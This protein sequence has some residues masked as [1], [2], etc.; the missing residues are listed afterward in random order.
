VNL[1]VTNPLTDP[2]WTELVLNHPRSSAFHQVGFLRA[3]AQTYE[4]EPAVVTASGPDCSLEDGL[5]FCRI[6][7]FLTGKRLV[8]LPFA[9]HCDPLISS[10]EQFRNYAQWLQN[11]RKTEKLKFIEIRPRIALPSSALEPGKTYR[12]HELD[13]EPSLEK[14]FSGL[15]KSSIQRRIQR[16]EREH[17]EYEVGTSR[18][19]L[20]SFYQLLAITRRRHRLLPQPMSWFENL[21]QF[22]D[23]NAQ[24]RLASKN[25][26]PLGAVLTLRHRNTVM[27]KYGCSDHKLH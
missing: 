12:F 2:R 4:Y 11:T 7:S 1:Y 25:G 27:Y 17:L 8:S 23:K 18:P 15:H 14:L 26:R 10:P 5:V 6:R 13:R 19:L 9:D 3:L 21:L 20:R 24:I 22:M 16:A